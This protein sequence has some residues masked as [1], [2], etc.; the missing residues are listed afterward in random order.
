M[1]SNSCSEEGEFI[2]LLITLTE[3]SNKVL[4]CV[5]HGKDYKN[6]YFYI[7]VMK[8]RRFTSHFVQTKLFYNF[9][10]QDRNKKNQD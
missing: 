6:K 1:N 8:S 5:R 7:M 3:T 9:G 4:V 10:S 2:I